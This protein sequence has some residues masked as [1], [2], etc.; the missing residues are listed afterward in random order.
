LGAGVA[1]IAAVSMTL[2]ANGVASAGAPSVVGQ[3]FS[4]ASSAMRSAGFTVKVGTTF[5]DSVRE[6]ECVVTSQATQ[7]KPQSGNHSTEGTV[8]VVSLNCSPHV[9]SAASPGYSAASPQ[10]RA[11]AEAAAAAAAAAGAT[12]GA[13][14][15]APGG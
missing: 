3:K 7:S 6:S 5:G 15:T 10:G 13:G 9:A 2:V 12:A 11:D 4:D 1:A 14:A 8:V